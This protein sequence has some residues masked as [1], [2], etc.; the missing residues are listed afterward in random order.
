[1]NIEE[2]AYEIKKT[3]QEL[4]NY[5]HNLKTHE[6]STLD[7]EINESYICEHKNF[8][9]MMEEKTEYLLELKKRYAYLY[10]KLNNIN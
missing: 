7:A 9:N 5:S 6:I 1:M 10:K 3:E 8:M 2:L 4:K